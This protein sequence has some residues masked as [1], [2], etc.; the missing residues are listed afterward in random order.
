M[1]F[2]TSKSAVAEFTDLDKSPVY[3]GTIYDPTGKW[4]AQ[5]APPSGTSVGLYS[6][7][8][9]VP[10][11]VTLEDGKTTKISTTLDDSIKLP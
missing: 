6:T 3:V 2:V 10:A 1:K 4:D 5:S 11:P 9:G 7:E 8:P